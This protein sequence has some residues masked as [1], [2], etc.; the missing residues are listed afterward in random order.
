[1]GVVKSK[2]YDMLLYFQIQMGAISNSSFLVQEPPNA[3]LSA[4]FKVLYKPAAEKQSVPGDTSHIE[5]LF[6][7]TICSYAPP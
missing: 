1:M 7:H 5:L 3:T 6:V 2:S 4:K